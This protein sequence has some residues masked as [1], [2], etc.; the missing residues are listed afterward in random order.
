MMYVD[1]NL[2]TG[3]GICL[4]ACTQG[5]ISLDDSRA[6]IDPSLCTDCGR[7][8]A[9]CLTRAI[10]SAEVVEYDTPFT[11]P[12]LDTVVSIPRP[13]APAHPPAIRDSG[14]PAPTPVPQKAGAL[15]VLE[16]VFSGAFGLLTWV[17]DQKK[18]SAATPKGRGMQGRTGPGGGRGCGS[19]RGGHRGRG[20]RGN[21]CRAGI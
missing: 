7:C 14:A 5:A 3:C 13:G 10:G 17:A 4:E 8:A 15:E 20:R 2:C 21:R 1:E 16:K 9:L 11:A 6:I 12:G 18:A 19:E